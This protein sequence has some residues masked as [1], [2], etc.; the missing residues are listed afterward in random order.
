[1]YP[2]YINIENTNRLSVFSFFVH[3]LRP[4][5]RKNFIVHTEIPRFIPS[6]FSVVP[7]S[8]FLLR[9]AMIL[10]VSMHSI[11][12]YSILWTSELDRGK[13][14]LSYF[15]KQMQSEVKIPC[16][17]FLTFTIHRSFLEQVVICKEMAFLQIPRFPRATSM[18]ILSEACWYLPWTS[19]CVNAEEY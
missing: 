13:D 8:E 14:T 2:L 10:E 9:D 5:W 17:D 1:M 18:D 6:C 3:L 11:R 4:R 7:S 19:S 12:R 16:C 15:H